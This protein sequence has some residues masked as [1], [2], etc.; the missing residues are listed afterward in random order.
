MSGYTPVY[1]KPYEGG[2]VN[3]PPRET[4][5]T[6]EILNAYDA[7]IENIETYLQG[8][9]A[10]CGG[11]AGLHDLVIE[12]SIS[13]GRKA[14]TETGRQSTAVGSDVAA[15][16][17]YSHA[18]GCSTTAAQICAHAEG[19][20]TEASGSCSHAEGADTKACGYA[21]HAEG[22]NTETAANSS[23]AHAEG[24]GTKASAPCTHA[25]G[26][27]TAASSSYAHAEGNGTKASGYASHA[28]GAATE[29]S[30]QYTHAEGNGANA[31][32]SGAHAEGEK[33]AAAGTDS[34]AEGYSTS[35][36][37]YCAHAEGCSTAAS[38]Q[39]SHTEGNGTK[40][41]GQGAHA[42]GNAA[43]ATAP[44]AHAE[45]NC[46]KADAPVSH[47][48]G[49]CTAAESQF[50]HVQGRYNVADSAGKYAHIV[51]NGTSENA[52]SNAHTLDWEGNAWFAGT[53][54]C[55]GIILTDT[56]D[57]TKHWLVQAT[58]GQPESN[59]TTPADS[60]IDL[61]DIIR[62]LTDIAERL[63]RL[64][65]NPKGTR[66]NPYDGIYFKDTIGIVN[67]M[68]S[69]GLYVKV[70]QDATDLEIFNAGSR[71]HAMYSPGHYSP[72]GSPNI[73]E[74][75]NRAA[76][77]LLI[78]LTPGTYTLNFRAAENYRIGIR[79]YQD[80]KLARSQTFD[81]PGTFE[82]GTGELIGLF[83]YSSAADGELSP[84][85]IKD[86]YASISI[87]IAD[88]TANA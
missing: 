50:Q 65:E 8:N 49:N 88:G 11:D 48:E 42:E 59:L 66:E 71:Y 68:Q 26:Y 9:Q 79:F 73:V 4:P 23:Y 86:R 60:I 31:S 28:E 52:R 24:Q 44:F 67:V 51:G 64:E 2:F 80:Q 6:A 22:Y 21:S 85:T 5:V 39:Y 82:V 33:T 25:E 43:E 72:T 77:R 81:A 58:D 40:A 41:S 75:A 74:Y 15:L 38:G 35:A 34:H 16:G 27:G 47:A 69:D 63:T 83:L 3:A 53:A 13:M 70:T 57:N 61:A 46:T 36:S 32:G 18:E 12:N 17:H 45:G 20:M 19:N 1:Q 14:D 30:E 7:A 84:E 37:E 62:R 56:A 78:D 54:E 76:Y 87:E 29:A 55:R 10:G